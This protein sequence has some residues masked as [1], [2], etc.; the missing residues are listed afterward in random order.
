MILALRQLGVAS[1]LPLLQIGG[2]PGKTA[3][4]H[5]RT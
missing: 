2:H 1:D 4:G 3:S 5:P